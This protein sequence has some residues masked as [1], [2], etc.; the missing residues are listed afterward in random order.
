M[1]KAFPELKTRTFTGS[2]LKG[3]PPPLHL[4]CTSSFSSSFPSLKKTRMRKAFFRSQTQTIVLICIPPRN[5]FLILVFLIV[6]NPR[7]HLPH[8][9][10]LHFGSTSPEIAFL[11]LIPFS[12]E[13]EDEEGVS[14]VIDPNNCVCLSPQNP[15][16]HPYFPHWGNISF[17]A[18][19]FP[20]FLSLN[21]VQNEENE[22]N[23]NGRKRLH[24]ID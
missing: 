10:F 12:K 23:V 11:I 19:S 20:S 2:A 1:R 8:P 21:N 3:S 7:K 5:P 24:F 4:V 6:D 18:S 13:N 22:E 17:F 15:L 9:H 14:Q 16:S